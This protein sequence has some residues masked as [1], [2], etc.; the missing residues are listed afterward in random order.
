MAP[1]MVI[2]IDQVPTCFFCLMF[3]YAVF[4]LV[5]FSLYY[6]SF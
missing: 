5:N 6:S 4:L 3:I 1:R 2:F